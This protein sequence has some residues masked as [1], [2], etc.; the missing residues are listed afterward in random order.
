M[1]ENSQE[2][3]AIKWQDSTLHLLDQRLLPA[4]VVWLEYSSHEEVAIAIR[5]MVVRG[6]PAIGIAAAFACVLLARVSSKI[7]NDER[8]ACFRSG[9]ECLHQARPTA[10]NLAWAL[11]Q[12]RMLADKTSWDELELA[13]ERFALATFEKDVSDNKAMGRLAVTEFMREGVDDQAFS[14]ITHCNTGT[15]ATGGYGTALGAIRAGF[16]SQLIDHV[17]VD[18]TRPWMQGARLTAWELQQDAVP[19]SLNVDSSAAWLMSNKNIRWAIVGADRITANGDVANKI[20][21]FALAIMAKYHKIKFMVVA[22]TSTIDMSL[23]SGDLIDIEMR[24][25]SELANI[26]GLEAQIADQPAL[27]PV[28]DVTPAALIDV[29][30]TEKGTVVRPTSEKLHKLMKA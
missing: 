25:G 12:A 18:E 21:T 22:P 3:V 10:V 30:I 16:E 27:N 23:E 17:Y 5:E 24:A 4:K 2:L 8:D 9:L 28:F 15:L 6:A 1:S 13:L 19:Y 11:D 29:L 26:S 20:G 14:V 7:A